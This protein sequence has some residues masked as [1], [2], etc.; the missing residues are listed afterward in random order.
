MNHKHMH[1]P[2][3]CTAKHSTGHP[4]KKKK[5]DKESPSITEENLMTLN[6]QLQEMIFTG[7]DQLHS[8]KYVK[9]DIKSRLKKKI[10]KRELHSIFSKL[11][12]TE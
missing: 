11:L 4:L 8:Y 3:I 7:T 10:K 6:L 1:F 12:N 2:T 9:N 5:A